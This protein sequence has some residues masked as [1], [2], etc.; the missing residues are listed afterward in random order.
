MIRNYSFKVSYFSLHSLSR[1][2]RKESN[3]CI[4]QKKRLLKCSDKKG[5]EFVVIATRKFDEKL[6]CTY[7]KYCYCSVRDSVN[8]DPSMA[9][10][11]VTTYWSVKSISGEIHREDACVNFV[12]LSFSQVICSAVDSIDKFHFFSKKE[13]LHGYTVL[14]N[15]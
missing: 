7:F 3:C 4:S 8:V 2:I 6:T 13:E 1:L 14:C 12:L 10:E 5:K 15:K 11:R 9:E